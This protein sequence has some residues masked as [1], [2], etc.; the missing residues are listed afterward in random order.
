M[1]KKGNGDAI[2]LLLFLTTGKRGTNDICPLQL[3]II[4][5]WDDDYLGFLKELAEKGLLR[6]FRLADEG[7]L[8][9]KKQ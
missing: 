2:Q 8:V 5:A 9:K 3:D 1:A 4:K 7:N 6:L